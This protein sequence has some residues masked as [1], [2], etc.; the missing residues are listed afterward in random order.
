MRV[1]GDAVEESALRNLESWIVLDEE[2][3]EPPNQA[4]RSS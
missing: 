4:K 1:T 2:A 3:V